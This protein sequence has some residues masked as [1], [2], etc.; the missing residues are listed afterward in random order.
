[1]QEFDRKVNFGPLEIINDMPMA[2]LD[3]VEREMY[4]QKLRIEVAHFK[5][6]EQLYAEKRAELLQLEQMYRKNQK[7]QVKTRDA[8]ADRGE[9]QHIIIE[10]LQDKV[11]E[12]D[13]KIGLVEDAMADLDEKTGEIKD[14]IRQRQ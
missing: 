9:T 12:V 14:Q 4:K 3:E 5:Q 1:M 7:V 6:R 11:K 10:N 13:R 8:G 2:Q